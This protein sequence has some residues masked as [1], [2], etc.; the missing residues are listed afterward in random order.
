MITLDSL[1]SI[2]I[3]YTLTP[4]RCLCA[5]RECAH[6]NNDS[7]KPGPQFAACI[8]T[9]LFASHS[10]HA[11]IIIGYRLS[12]PEPS[13]PIWF[14][15]TR[16]TN[17]WQTGLDNPNVINYGFPG[18]LGILLGDVNGD[19]LDDKMIYQASGGNMQ[20]VAA[21]TQDGNF[22][23]TD[24]NS[25]NGDNQFPWWDVVNMAPQFA[26][27][28]GDEIDDSCVTVAVTDS[29]L[30]DVGY[31]LGGE[32]SADTLYWAA[33]RSQGVVGIS[34]NSGGGAANFTGWNAFGVPSL[35]DVPL[36]GDFNGDG[37][38]D[39]LLYRTS[40]NS[41]FIDYSIPGSWGD[42]G[43]DVG[44]IAIGI[45]G[46]TL[47]ASDINDDGLDDLVVARDT[48]G[49][50]PG[51]QTLYGFYNDGNGF[52]SLNGTQ[53]DII[54]NWGVNDRI[55]FGRISLAEVGPSDLTGFQITSV[56]S[57]G[58]GLALE[59]AFFAP[60]AA[61]Y[62]IEASLN[63]E[64]ESW[65]DV[66]AVEVLAVGSAD[67]SVSDAELDTAFPATDPRPKVFLRIRV[68]L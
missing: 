42:G 37:I 2:K 32:A 50:T 46:D 49:D 26:D 29:N 65:Q 4:W 35:G 34:N 38:A 44:P 21:Y 45:P 56:T 27:V 61:T 14:P 30:G 47:L 67:F 10:V 66:G 58:P 15:T 31:I 36:L 64:L 59:G 8:A 5:A 23:N 68:T 39:R 24:F 20:I 41:A 19:G 1:S 62:Q 52:G 11:E 43:V 48:S 40:T 60:I 51:L 12:P 17:D 6:Q 22:T 33:W 28:D 13:Q 54:T 25:P 7:M 18:I 63:P 57:A 55:L 3:N 53:P 9:L 16:T